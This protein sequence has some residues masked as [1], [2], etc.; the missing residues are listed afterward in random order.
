MLANEIKSVVISCLNQSVS[1][2]LKETEVS[3]KGTKF[4]ISRSKEKRVIFCLP[5][6]PGCPGVP[7]DPGGPAGPSLPSRPSRPMQSKI[8]INL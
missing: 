5:G 6:V 4:V 1:I 3:H 7:G 8:T 2:Y